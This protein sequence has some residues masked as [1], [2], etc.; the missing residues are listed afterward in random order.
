[1]SGRSRSMSS[2]VIIILISQFTTILKTIIYLWKTHRTKYIINESVDAIILEAKIQ[3]KGVE[4]LIELY[5]TPG[6]SNTVIIVT[7]DI[8]HRDNI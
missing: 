1:M 7:R 2:G 3:R 8:T 4:S 6:V 5:I